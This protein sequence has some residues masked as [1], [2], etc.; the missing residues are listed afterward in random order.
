[1]RQKDKRVLL[2]NGLIYV[3]AVYITYFVAGITLLKVFTLTREAV[4]V[5]NMLYLGIGSMIAFFGLLEVKDFFWYGRWIS[6]GII[7]RF[8]HTMEE[9]VQHTVQ[10]PK[11][12]FLFGIFV[13]L[14]ELPCTGAPY[15][16]VL[17]LMSFMEFARA[18]PLLI[19]YNFIFVLPLIFIIYL[20]YNGVHVKRI[21]QWRIAHRRI[22]RLFIGL[23]L[24]GLSVLL[25]FII[26]R[27]YAAILLV[28][29]ATI[30]AIMYILWKFNLIS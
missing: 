5:A 17:T 13:T 12:A 11:A 30:V 19:I 2:R 7:P 18:L 27:Q 3:A 6:L 22:M 21:E 15:L 4:S 14:I 25:F 8:V 20:A 23:F 16:A 26:S 29:E 1:M 24:L 28:V 9:Y 10:S